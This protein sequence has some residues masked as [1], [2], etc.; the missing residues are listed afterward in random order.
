M[1]VTETPRSQRQGLKPKY[2]GYTASC[3]N[4]ESKLKLRR[5]RDEASH[6]CALSE[7]W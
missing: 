3:G 5:V 1:H 4:V 6:G 7:Y 2:S